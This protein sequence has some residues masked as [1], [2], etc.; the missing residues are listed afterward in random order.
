L[1]ATEPKSYVSHRRKA[2]SRTFNND[3]LQLCVQLDVIRRV[4]GGI[5]KEEGEGQEL[6][7]QATRQG[8][9][10]GSGRRKEMDRY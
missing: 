6:T 5:R 2:G 1:L 9:K 7:C 8:R 10:E 4:K 3:E